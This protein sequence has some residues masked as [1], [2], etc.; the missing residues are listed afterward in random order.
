MYIYDDIWWPLCSPQTN[1]QKLDVKL[2]H[3][4]PFPTSIIRPKK[5]APISKAPIFGHRGD[6]CLQGVVP[7]ADVDRSP[8]RVAGE[9]LPA[10]QN[11][12]VA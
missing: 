11:H 12:V 5:K 4:H 1:G 6:N 3:V 2:F 8:G 10:A 9:G 7:G